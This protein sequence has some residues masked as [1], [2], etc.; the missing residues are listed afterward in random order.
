MLWGQQRNSYVQGNQKYSH[1]ILAC[2]MVGDA[3]SRGRETMGITDFAKGQSE[4]I[5]DQQNSNLLCLHHIPEYYQKYDY[6]FRFQAVVEVH[7]L[8]HSE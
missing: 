8:A 4:C 6:G 1:D 5:K 2:N 3:E 7:Y